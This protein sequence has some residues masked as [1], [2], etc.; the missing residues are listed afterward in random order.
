MS[1]YEAARAWNRRIPCK[2]FRLSKVRYLEIKLKNNVGLWGSYVLK[3]GNNLEHFQINI[4]ILFVLWFNITFLLFLSCRTYLYFCRLTWK[5]IF[6]KIVDVSLFASCMG[7][8][9]LGH[10]SQQPNTHFQFGIPL[11]LEVQWHIVSMAMSV[12]IF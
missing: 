4:P 10:S 1:D 12:A 7:V 6:G 8:T 2:F 9:I 3:Q 5:I 11:F